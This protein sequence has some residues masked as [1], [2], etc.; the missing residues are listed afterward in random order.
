M[1]AEQL[2]ADLAAATANLTGWIED[3]ADELAADRIAA[4]EAIAAGRVAAIEQAWAA[5]RERREAVIDLLRRHVAALDQFQQRHIR[6]R[7]VP[8]GDTAPP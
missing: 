1:S 2:A 4:A 8:A 3:R 6:G 7:C 5:E